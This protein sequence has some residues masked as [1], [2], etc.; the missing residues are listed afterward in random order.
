MDDLLKAVDDAFPERRSQEPQDDM[1][2]RLAIAGAVGGRQWVY[3][4]LIL[5]L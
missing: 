4:L 2:E 5:F 1:T 3:L